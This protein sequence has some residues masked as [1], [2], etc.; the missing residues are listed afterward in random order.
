MFLRRPHEKT[1]RLAACD[2]FSAM[3]AVEVLDCDTYDRRPTANGPCGSTRRQPH[4]EHAGFGAIERH[5][6]ALAVAVEIARQR[7]LTR[8]DDV[9]TKHEARAREPQNRAE[10][11]AH[12]DAVYI[13]VRVLQASGRPGLAPARARARAFLGCP[14]MSAHLPVEAA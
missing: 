1:G 10:P 14:E 8:S 11:E 7:Q 2:E 5:A 6:V 13:L 3:I 12:L 4:L 9:P